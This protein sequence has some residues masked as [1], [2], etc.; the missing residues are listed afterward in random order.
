MRYSLLML[1]TPDRHCK[2]F[3]FGL[4][5]CFCVVSNIAFLL[6]CSVCKCLTMGEA[7]L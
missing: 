3:T 1:N 6:Y 4:Q 2:L 5:A 7:M